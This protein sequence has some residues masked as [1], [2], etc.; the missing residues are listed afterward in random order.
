MRA[1]WCGGGTPPELSDQ[2]DE[3][4]RTLKVENRE[5][6]AFKAQKSNQYSV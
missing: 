3:G 1:D 6:L 4:K 5:K 2:P